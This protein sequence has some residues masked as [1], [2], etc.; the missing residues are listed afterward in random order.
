MSEIKQKAKDLHEYFKAKIL[1]GDYLTDKV[2]EHYLY[3]KID[4]FRFCLWM[5]NS[6]FAFRTQSNFDVQN[7]MEIAFNQKEKTKAYNKAKK[8]FEEP[9]KQLL[10]KQKQEQF[11]KLKK[12]LGIVCKE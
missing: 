10:L 2:T 1:Q 9:K 4:G 5:A 11:E 12:E 8:L 3:I 6:D 7:F